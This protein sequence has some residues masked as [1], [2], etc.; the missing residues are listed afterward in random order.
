MS[1]TIKR[2]TGFVGSAMKINIRING[3]KISSVYNNQTLNIEIPDG[4]NY[5]K[6]GQFGLKSDE[7][8]VKDGDVLQITHTMW[9]R[10]VIPFAIIIE[11]LTIFI[12][13]STYRLPV[14]FILLSLIFVITFLLLYFCLMHF[15]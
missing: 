6:V 3:E 2:N 12:P 9:H 5:L 4:E 15:I 10:W 7:L 14:F 11:A 8:K 1:I 13:N